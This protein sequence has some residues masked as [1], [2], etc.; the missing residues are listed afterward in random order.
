MTQITHTA[1]YETARPPSIAER[2]RRRALF[3]VLL[4]A[5]GAIAGAG[6]AFAKG[7]SYVSR[8]AFF[9]APTAFD[10]G[11]PDNGV[12]A[13]RHLATQASLMTSSSVLRAALNSLPPSITVKALEDAVSADPE[14]GRNVVTLTVSDRSRDDAAS[15]AAAVAQAYRKTVARNVAQ[16]ASSAV[17]A[18]KN[19]QDGAASSSAAAVL[20]RAEAYNDGVRFAESPTT[21]RS[22]PDP[23]ILAVLGALVAA[24]LGLVLVLAPVIR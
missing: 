19:A 2:V 17:R 21:R 12:D 18:L 7:T 6:L 16:Q 15:I 14:T 1:Q 9:L 5:L 20:S 24:L 22:K 3:L 11:G 8:V 23:V 10:I 4:V 13:S